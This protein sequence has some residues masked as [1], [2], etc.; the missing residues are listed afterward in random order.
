[1]LSA[2]SRTAL[3]GASAVLVLGAL[4]WIVGPGASV[5]GQAVARPNVVLV[6][7]CTLRRDQLSPY[8][9]LSAASPFLQQLAQQGARFAHAVD[10]APWTRA[11][12]TAI[13][14]GHHPIEVG[15]IEPLPTPS[16][17]RL[18][19][20]VTTLAE[21]LSAAGYETIGLTANPNL[22]RV[23]GFAQGFD[24]YYEAQGLWGEQEDVLKIPA[25]ELAQRALEL[26]D[27]RQRRD[28]PLYL[29][30][31][32]IDPHEPVEVPRRRSRAMAP[33]GVPP[34]VADYRVE[35]RRWD[36]GLRV[37]WEGLQRRGFSRDD[38]LL[39]VINDHGEGLSWPPEH[40]GGH[41]HH[42]LPSVLDMPWVVVGP[43]VAV[44]HL[45]DGIASQIDVHP[46]ILGLVGIEGYT[47]PG[48][49]LSGPIRGAAHT[50]LDRAYAD[51]WFGRMSRAAIYTEHRL[52]VHDFEDLAEQLGI[53]RILPRTA[54]FDRRIDPAGREP[55][56]QPDEELIAEL[57]AWRGQMWRAFERWPHHERLEAG[58]SEDALLDALGYTE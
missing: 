7:G 26:V 44:D 47:G 30:M 46:T 12:S 10:A 21:R 11:A 37:L 40:G 17:R 5:P 20:E 35:V 56:A 38:T 36:N 53:E 24:A 8:G 54:C 15:M 2:M 14:T 55:L 27:A 39:V 43:G 52:C 50:G 42:L 33:D 22:N 31:V 49:D 34:R 51:T 9:G 16:R 57:E 19:A 45:I 1:M 6:I 4:A 58:V 23:F 3:A 32:T 13:V 41:G 18:S 25:T 48:H 28:D 29:R